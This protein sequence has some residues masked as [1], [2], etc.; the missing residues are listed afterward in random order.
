MAEV[1]I[2]FRD[3]KYYIPL[4][5]MGRPTTLIEEKTVELLNL[6]TKLLKLLLDHAVTDIQGRFAPFC[7]PVSRNGH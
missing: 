7:L 2:L 3:A 5:S 4:Y 1:A 6:V